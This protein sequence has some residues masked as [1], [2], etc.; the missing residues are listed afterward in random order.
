MLS[1][2]FAAIQY[3]LPHHV[4]SRAVGK[5]MHCERPAVKQWLINRAISHYQIDLSEAAEPDATQYKTFNA[6]FTRALK[7]DAR[8]IDDTPQRLCSP[9]DGV[10]SQCGVI[11][12]GRLLQAK[13]HHFHLTELLGGET[14]HAQR[15]KD[16]NFATIYLSPRDYHRVHMP[17]DGVLTDMVHVPGRLFSVNQ[18][19]TQHVPNLFARNERV[20]AFF[21]TEFGPMAVILVG[22]MLVAS[23]EMTEAGIITPPTQHAVQHW[24]YKKT[25]Q[26]ACKKGQELGR[27]H[28]GS[29][30][31][32]ITPKSLPSFASVHSG[33]CVKM[34]QCL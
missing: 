17:Y 4:L 33:Q 15:L 1:R 6:F 10:V 19:T 23:I 20:V 3:T 8:P 2:L 5:L 16:G 12:H 27:F 24:H 13:G 18:A 21:D 34:G 25:S 31:I 28:F 14:D 7:P 30:V 32:V 29:T 11:Q 26:N 22:A 9:A